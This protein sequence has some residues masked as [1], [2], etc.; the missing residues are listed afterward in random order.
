MVWLKE[1]SEGLSTF[2][3]TVFFLANT[4]L[5]IPLSLLAHTIQSALIVIEYC[6]S[7]KL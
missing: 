6:S 2:I 7:V 1:V 4:L 3:A 5:K